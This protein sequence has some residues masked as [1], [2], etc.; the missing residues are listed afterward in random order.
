[1]GTATLTI[2]EGALKPLSELENLD[3]LQAPKIEN[4]HIDPFVLE[5]YRETLA[6]AAGVMMAQQERL[7]GVG[8]AGTVDAV[9]G[10]F[11][12]LAENMQTLGETVQGAHVAA[13]VLPGMLGA[14]GKRTYLVMVQNN[15][16]PRTTGGIPGAVI[17][18]TADNGTF[19]LGRYSSGGA[20]ANRDGIDFEL[21]PDELNAF[22]V[23]ML[24]YPQDVNFTPE[25]PRPA[26]ALTG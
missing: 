12:E 6:G 5:P 9:R 22:S 16:E 24:M 13:E 14:E 8:L 20:M 25:F 2:S 19:A 15:A 18:V 3:A 17:E 4:G 10:P 1:A 11:V 23:R 7:A 26:Q 21:T